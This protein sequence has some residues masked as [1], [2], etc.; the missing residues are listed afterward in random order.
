[1]AR[2]DKTSDQAQ[3]AGNAA[4]PDVEKTSGAVATPDVDTTAGTSAPH[5]VD[6][7]GKAR[8]AEHAEK[9][10]DD[11]TPVISRRSLCVGLG[12]VAA[13][14]ALGGLKAVPAQAKVRPPGAQDTDT[15]LSACIRCEKCIEVCPHD[16]VTPAHIEDG[17]VGMR[18]PVMNFDASYC[19]FCAEA[20]DGHPLCNEVCP[21]GAFTLPVDATPE[22]T[23]IGKARIIKDWCLAY[24]FVGCR[25]CYDACPY[26]AI[27]LDDQSRPVIVDD[28][29]N[30]CG[31]CE[32]VCVSLTEGQIATGATSRAA[33]VEPVETEGAL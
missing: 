19:D 20:N 32:S 3:T 18:T 30:G 1:M 25:F 13:T 22:N 8:S 29:C 7:T 23:V 14:L 31:A 21:T 12:G 16:V 27:I 11:H 33:I 4:T 10:S 28:K 26:E 15:L 2:K 17:I 9:A 24:H 5:V 6:R